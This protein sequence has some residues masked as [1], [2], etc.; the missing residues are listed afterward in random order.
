[1][2]VYLYEI[3]QELKFQSKWMEQNQFVQGGVTGQKGRAVVM[4]ATIITDITEVAIV[5]P[6][7][8]M[9]VTALWNGAWMSVP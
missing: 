2:L 1:M 9:Q 3:F 5:A 4:V 7:L 6:A 8:T